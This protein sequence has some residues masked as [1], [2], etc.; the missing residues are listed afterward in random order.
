MSRDYRL[1]V[2][3]PYFM[4]LYVQKCKSVASVGPRWPWARVPCTL[5]TP[6]CYATERLH[7]TMQKH[8]VNLMRS[9][10]KRCN[11]AQSHSVTVQQL[12]TTDYGVINMGHHCAWDTSLRRPNIRMAYSRRFIVRWIHS[13]PSSLPR[14]MPAVP[15]AS[16][17]TFRPIE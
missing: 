16:N 13:R 2:F 9:F 7:S 15:Q 1:R 17:D 3:S 11:D 14:I 4:Y 6:Y 12:S 10:T 5:C 8:S